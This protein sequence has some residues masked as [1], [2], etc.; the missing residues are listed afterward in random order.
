MQILLRA[1]VVKEGLINAG[2]Q[3]DMHEIAS[4]PKSLSLK[5]FAMEFYVEAVVFCCPTHRYCT[6][7]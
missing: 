1:V 6:V 7:L 5:S 4:I 2:V 3:L